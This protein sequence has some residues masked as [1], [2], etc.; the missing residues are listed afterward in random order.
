[1]IAIKIGHEKIPTELKK[2]GAILGEYAQIG[3]NSILLPGTLIGKNSIVSAGTTF[4]GF[5]APN[6]MLY[7]ETKTIIK[8]V[9]TSG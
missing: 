4:G 1:L 6:R 7:L 5:L 3:C 2:L 9:V 8:D